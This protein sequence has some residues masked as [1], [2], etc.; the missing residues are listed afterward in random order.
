[1]ACT[2][3]ADPRPL[4][5]LFS[6][7]LGLAGCEP[8][9][10]EPPTDDDD[11]AADDDAGDDDAP[12]I[13]TAY[14][15]LDELPAAVLV[16]CGAAAIGEDGMP[17]VFSVPLEGDTVTP[18]AFRVET[19]A[20]PV[21]PV[22]ATLRPADEPLEL[23]TVLLAGPFGTAADPPLAVEV[24]GDVRAADGASIQGLRTDTITPLAAGPSVVLA[25]AFEPTTPG[26]DPECPAG[27]T[28]VVQFVFEG[29]V[30]GPDGSALGEP[31]RLGV[32][33]HLAGGDVVPPT[34]LGDD[35]PDNYVHACTDRA[36][37]VE[38][39]SVAE[40]LF[41]DPGDDPNPAVEPVAVVAR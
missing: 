8:V 27:T 33:L 34:A 18:A 15:G 12:T 9:E 2:T 7:L 32:S 5:G 19:S 28:S 20:G 13:L 10:P 21:E 37:A 35:D 3:S 24:V 16:L 6:L 26:L 11:S 14:H 40:G 36:E 25:E 38:F 39:V 29:G 22:C 23:H 41:H 1:M 30:T 17:V 4:L 31:Q